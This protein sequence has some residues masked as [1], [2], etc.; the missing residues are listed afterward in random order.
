MNSDDT[1]A[2]SVRQPETTGGGAT[3][4]PPRLVILGTVA[5]LTRGGNPTST[6]G[7]FAGSSV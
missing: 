3:Y 1:S 5:E 2:A 6:D 4:V 7:I